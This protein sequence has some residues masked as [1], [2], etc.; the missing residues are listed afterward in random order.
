MRLTL[1][2]AVPKYRDRLFAAAFSVCRDPADA[3]DAVQDAFIKYHTLS[4]DF[5]D[6]D[7]LRAWLLRVTINRARDLRASFWRRNRVSWEEYAG[8]LEFQAPEDDR[9]FRA[10]MA[11]PEKYRVAIHLHYYEGY[12]VAETAGLLHVREGTVK[13]Q[14]SRGRTLLKTMLKEEWDDDE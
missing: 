6:E 9:L 12:S 2:E 8:S 4:K 1:D 13:S 7:H 3:D 5:R 11:L 14:L 10:V